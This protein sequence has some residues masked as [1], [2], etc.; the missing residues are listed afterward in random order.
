MVNEVSLGHK[1]RQFTMECS[2][3]GIKVT[4]SGGNKKAVKKA[5]AQKMLDIILVSFNHI[6]MPQYVIYFNILNMK[7]IVCCI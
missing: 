4:A 5:A 3:N 1:N 2:L 6:F 7:H